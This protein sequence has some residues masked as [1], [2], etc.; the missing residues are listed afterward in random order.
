LAD[1]RISGII[2]YAILNGTAW[3]IVQIS[4]GRIIP[5]DYDQADYWSPR[6]QGG[7][8]PGWVKRLARG[9][10]N[11]WHEYNYD[12]EDEQHNP[13]CYSETNWDGRLYTITTIEASQ[14]GLTTQSARSWEMPTLPSPV[15][16]SH[17][18]SLGPQQDALPHMPTRGGRLP[19][20]REID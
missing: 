3:V 2:T 11:F 8:I 18:T 1:L 6:M 10:R 7:I 12:E 15:K 20:L 17:S 14:T 16:E 5:Y 4:N 19:P 9:K 13:E